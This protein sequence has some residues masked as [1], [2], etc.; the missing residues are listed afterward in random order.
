MS[1]PGARIAAGSAAFRRINRAMAFGGFSTFALLYCVQPLMP[2]LG[3]DFGLSPAQSSL[4]LSVAT[5]TLALALLGSSNV[6]E[7]FGRKKVMVGSM[8]SGAVLTLGCAFASDYLHL[9]ALRACMGLMLGGR[10]VRGRNG[11]AGE[12]GHIAFPLAAGM[13]PV[14]G[15]IEAYL[16]A[17]DVTSDST[18]HQE[19][20]DFAFI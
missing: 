10:L 2:L 3:R 9:V 16:G 1:A 5:A 17:V 8:L 19:Q 14:P 12:I 7:R 4:V 18:V 15:E 11:A 6:A 20:F 13:V